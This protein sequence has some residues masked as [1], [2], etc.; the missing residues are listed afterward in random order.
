[1]KIFENKKDL[2]IFLNTQK[3]KGLAV[4]LVPTMGALH[5]GHASLISKGLSENDVV[6]VSIFVNPTQF[7]K[8]EDLIKYPRTLDRDIAL[9]KSISDEMIVVYAPSV[10]DIYG[11]IVKPQHFDY[12][13]LEHEMEGR[14]R[15]GHFDGVGTIVKRLF[16]IVKP[17][18]AYFG[19]KDFQ[20]L[21]IIKKLVEKHNLPVEVV[22]CA[23]F[24]ANDGL[25]MSSRNMRL[26]SHY[27]A[28]VPFIYKTL[29]TAKIK[30][31]TDS[32]ESI[33]DW[34]SEQFK[35][36]ELLELE[37]F[38]IANTNTLKS[39]EKKSRDMPYRAFVAVYADGVRLID[40]IA[41][42]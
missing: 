26:E 38:I 15:N 21:M 16:E 34:V 25:A 37:Y 20:Q 10:E 29:Q 8:E 22:G 19:E 27:R 12:E 39:I 33:T 9:L 5:E 11:A 42:N 18:K 23:I 30:F 28:A 31:G 32:A 14:F 13:G 35:N 36:H 6:V 7:D 4:G 24:R 3:N 1:M 41:L 2:S 17:D 40:N